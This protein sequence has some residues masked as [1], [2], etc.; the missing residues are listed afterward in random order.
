MAM[1]QVGR[2]ALS[3]KG[4]NFYSVEF[5]TNRGIPRGARTYCSEDFREDVAR[6]NINKM[7]SKITSASRGLPACV[8]EVTA[9]PIEIFKFS[10]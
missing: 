2:L 4:Q 5:R 8:F 7:A 3:L 10:R 1:S 9:R 6:R